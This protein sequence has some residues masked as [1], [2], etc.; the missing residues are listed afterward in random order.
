[1]N[2]DA[3]SDKDLHELERLT[4]EL[5]K[6]MRKAKLQDQP[7]VELLRLLEQETGKVRRERFDAV[8]PEFRGY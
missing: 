3:V 5:L 7:L 8:N 1:M 2:F 6:V 4:V